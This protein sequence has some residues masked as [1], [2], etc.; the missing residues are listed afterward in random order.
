MVRS[1]KSRTRTA[2]GR[3]FGLTACGELAGVVAEAL[4]CRRS[5]HETYIV[6]MSSDVNARFVPARLL[7]PE[8]ASATPTTAGPARDFRNRSEISIASASSSSN[9]TAVR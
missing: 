7:K 4:I 2:A 9:G 8:K 5:V 6:S 3:E 1:N